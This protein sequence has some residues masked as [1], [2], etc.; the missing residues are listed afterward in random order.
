MQTRWEKLR[1]TRKTCPSCK[2]P[3]RLVKIAPESAATVYRH[4]A[5]GGLA[6][7]ETR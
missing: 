6:C 3:Q 5:T 2:K 1:P 4:E 7:K